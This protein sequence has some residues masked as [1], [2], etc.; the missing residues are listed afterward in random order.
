LQG[1]PVFEGVQAKPKRGTEVNTSTPTPQAD[2]LPELPPL[3]ECDGKI[4]GCE[5]DPDGDFPE[6][7]RAKAV[8]Q[9]ATTYARAAVA[10]ALQSRAVPP[11]CPDV[12]ALRVAAQEALRISEYLHT[13]DVLQPLAWHMARGLSIRLADLKGQP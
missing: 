13:L 4:F 3:P 7:W 9:Y 5:S 10:A 1:V 6:G 8:K 2:G 11:A 12:D